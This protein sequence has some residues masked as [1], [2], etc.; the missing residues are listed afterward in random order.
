M[1]L[2]DDPETAADG[3]QSL[4]LD[5]NR[6]N[7]ELAAARQEL[8]ELRALFDL[9]WRRMGEATQMWRAERPE[10]RALTLP[11]LGD[12]LGWLMGEARAGYGWRERHA[13][14]TSRYER[15]LTALRGRLA[16]AEGGRST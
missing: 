13:I 16:D 14:D 15:E 12:L 5:R 7:T 8:R 4:V 6:L 1:I 2:S 10:E 11:D 3:G 9:Q